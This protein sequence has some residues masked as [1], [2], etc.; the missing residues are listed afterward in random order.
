MVSITNS[1]STLIQ[2]GCRPLASAQS[3]LRLL[4]CTHTQLSQSSSSLIPNIHEAVVHFYHFFTSRML[5]SR[6]VVSDSLGPHSL[7][8][9]P[10]LSLSPGVRSNSCPVSRWCHP[11][12]SSPVAPFSSYPQS[13]PASGSFPMSRLFEWGDHGI[14]SFSIS[15]SNE[16]Y[17][18][19]IA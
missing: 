16:G 2:A 9:L 4:F 7:Q 17:T 5:F 15:P 8:G 18:N 19:G 6:Q 1:M 14:G 3:S 10:G 13:F 12:I 11:T